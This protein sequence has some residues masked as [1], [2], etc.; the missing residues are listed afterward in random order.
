M[1]TPAE[2]AALKRR[3]DVLEASQPS[4]IE[5]RRQ[6]QAAEEAQRMRKSVELA[7]RQQELHQANERQSFE[8]W[9]RHEAAE[10]AERAANQGRFR[11]SCG[12]WRDAGGRQLPDDQAAEAAAVDM[13]RIAKQKDERNA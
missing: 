8:N 4:A 1:N 11:D 2:I 12:I 3:L 6:R 13:Q 9:K 10:K 5:A 7:R